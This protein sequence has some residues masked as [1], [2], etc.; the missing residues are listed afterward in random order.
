M[1]IAVV[2][3]FLLILGVFV[4]VTEVPVSLTDDEVRGAV[5]EAVSGSTFAVDESVL[6]AAVRV[7]VAKLE[8]GQR[9]RL[10]YFGAAYIA[11]WL[12]F[13]LYVVYLEGQQRVLDQRLSQ[14]EDS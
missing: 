3:S 9:K 5:T 10:K 11:I 8:A 7:S 13:V 6:T 1:K 4:F 14:L 12:V 2:A